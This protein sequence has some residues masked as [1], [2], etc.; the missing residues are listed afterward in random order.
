MTEWMKGPLAS[1]VAEGVEE[2][3]RQ[4]LLPKTFVEGLRSQFDQK[5]IHWT[6]LWAVVV[7][8][9]FLARQRSACR[10]D[11]DPALHSFA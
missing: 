10:L 9:H 1:F 5:Q 6:R 2:V 8:G 3:I 4:Q 7:L 11:E